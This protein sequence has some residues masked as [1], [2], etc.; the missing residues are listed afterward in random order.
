MVQE[1][2]RGPVEINYIVSTKDNNLHYEDTISVN[3][4]YNNTEETVQRGAV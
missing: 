4:G 3:V 1:D 2:S